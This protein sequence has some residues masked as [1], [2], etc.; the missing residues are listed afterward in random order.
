M[1]VGIY[2]RYSSDLQ[3]AAS[4]EDQVRVCRER[5]AREGWVLLET[6]ADYAVSGGSMR[7]RPGLQAL[8]AAARAGEVDLVLAEALD[9]LSRDQEDIAGIFKRLTHGG[10]RLVTLSEGEISEL[11]IGLKGTMNALYLKDLAQKT[12]RGL[13]GRVEAGMSGGGNSYGYRVVRRLLADGTP[14]KGEREIEPA[15]AAVVQR[16]FTEYTAGLSPRQIAARLNAEAIPGPRGGT[17]TPSTIHGSRQRRNGILN[18]EMYVGRLVWNRQRFAKDPDTGKRVSRLN[19]REEWVVTEVPA[20]RLIDDDVFAKA[21]GQKAR[22][23]GWAG[24]KRQVKRRV[25]TGLV[26]CA[27][28]GGAMTTNRDRYYCAARR[29][30]GTCKAT[31]G[32]AVAELEGRVLDGLARLL[33]GNEAA[34]AAFTE[35]FERELARLAT[36]R[37][38]AGDAQRRQIVEVERGI[39]RCMEFIL[40]GDGAPG[41]VRGTLMELEARKSRLEAELRAATAEVSKVTIHPNLPDLYRRRVGALSELLVDEAMRAE[42]MEALRGL[43]TRIAVGPTETRGLCTVTIH[44]GLAGI[45]AFCADPAK[46]AGSTEF[47]VAGA[48]IEPAAFRL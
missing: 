39:A 31:H 28:C 40:S 2:A 5:I 44:G 1:R 25:F 30:R 33:V 26:T 6:Y 15:E 4:I 12:R 23:A 8:M 43:V 32:I 27:C 11:H 10:V 48:G 7:A 37:R 20:L 45:L 29:D 22:Y 36:E 46:S 34:L 16:I 21:Q 17:W 18:N 19:P 13:R 24:N 38:T 3:S 14:V 35:E 9:R 42:A 47:L 41:A